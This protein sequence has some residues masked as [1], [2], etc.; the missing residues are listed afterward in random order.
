[1]ASRV[2]A[3]NEPILF[4]A[5]KEFLD[6]GFADAS[7]RTIAG[8]AGVSTSTIYTRYVDKEGLFKHIVEPASKAMVEY[9]R[10]SLEGFN[11]LSTKDKVEHMDECSDVGFSGLIDIIYDYF[12]E[13]NLIV[14]CSPN[15]FYHD[16]LE[17]IVVL[18]MECTKKFMT[19]VGCKAFINNEISDGFLHVVTSAFYSGLF[20]VV[21]HKMPKDEATNYINQLRKFYQS[22]WNDYF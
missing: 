11:E 17:E 6:K 16:F 4:H 14:T 9:V 5:K 8:N 18:D 19:A 12:D 2:E 7:L 22:G 3:F 21:I 20:E 10:R 15:V 13:F 1:M